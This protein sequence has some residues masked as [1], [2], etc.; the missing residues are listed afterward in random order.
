MVILNRDSTGIVV[1]NN[2]K[3]PFYIVSETLKTIFLK[4]RLAIT[5]SIST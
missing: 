4:N 1:L 3:A 2:I 5:T